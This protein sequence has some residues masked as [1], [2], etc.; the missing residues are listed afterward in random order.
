ME[1]MELLS[2]IEFNF[3]YEKM[4]LRTPRNTGSECMG[5][6]RKMKLTLDVPGRFY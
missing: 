5:K 1:M 3:M 6:E 4:S 2:W